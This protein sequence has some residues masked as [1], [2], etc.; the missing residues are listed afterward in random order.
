MAKFFNTSGPCRPE[1]HY[2]IDIGERFKN[3]RKLIDNKHYFILH[4]PMQTGKTTNMIGF[5]RQL[6]EEGRYIA[7]YV[8]V[9][10]GPVSMHPAWGDLIF[11]SASEGSVLHLN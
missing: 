3:V 1:D 8:N 7:L 2:I 11:A 10:P 6:N 4:A 9:E 5:T